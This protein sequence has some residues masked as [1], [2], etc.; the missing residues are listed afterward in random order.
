VRKEA[1]SIIEIR[2]SF[3]FRLDS[4]SLSLPEACPEGDRVQLRHVQA[5]LQILAP[6]SRYWQSP[7]RGSYRIRL[8]V[9][10]WKP[11]IAELNEYE[12]HR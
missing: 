9:P 10:W 7:I 1:R 2:C 4:H 11:E 5:G 12:I 6:D 3:C 8:V